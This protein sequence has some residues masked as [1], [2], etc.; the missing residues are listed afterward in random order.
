[1]ESTIEFT[2][3]LSKMIARKMGSPVYVTNSISFENAGMGGTVEEEMEAL[4]NI[5][6]VVLSHLRQEKPTVNGAQP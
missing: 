2:T 3:R 4:K 5:L 1:M 6:E